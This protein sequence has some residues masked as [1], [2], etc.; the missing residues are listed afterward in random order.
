[1]LVS[2]HRQGGHGKRLERWKLFIDNLIRA[3]GL[4]L[5]TVAIFWGN[6]AMQQFGEQLQGNQTG[7]SQRH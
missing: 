5:F 3:E 7:Q 1:M 2:R 4:K 6:R